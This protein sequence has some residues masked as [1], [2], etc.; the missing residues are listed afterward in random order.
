MVALSPEIQTAIDVAVARAIARRFPAARETFLAIKEAAATLGCH[1][2][3]VRRLIHDGKL[4]SVGS[5][6]LLR[7]PQSAIDD[8]AVRNSKGIAA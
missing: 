5:G 8:Y 7:V 3:T 6:K 4:R 1:R 2:D